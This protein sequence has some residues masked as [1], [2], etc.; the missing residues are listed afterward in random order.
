MRR[1]LHES[2]SKNY[3][4]LILELIGKPFFYSIW[5]VVMLIYILSKALYSWLNSL[6]FPR[7]PRKKLAVFALLSFSTLLFFAIAAWIFSLKILYELPA[8]EELAQRQ[9]DVSS[10]IYD[11]NG[12]LLYS[13]YKD[14]NRSLIKTDE[15]PQQVKLATLAAEDSEFYNHQGYSIKGMAR[16]LWIFIRTG[17]VTGGSTITQQLVKNALLSNEKTLVRK[18]KEFILSLGVE[19]KYTKDQIL[20]MYLNE[21][22]YG[23]V[24]YGIKEAARYY[25]DKDLNQLTIAEAALLAGLTKSPSELSPFGNE[26]GLAKN[27]ALEVIDLM[28]KDGFITEEQAKRAEQEKLPYTQN[29]VDIKA[30]HFVM[31]VRDQLEKSGW[32]NL[33]TQGLSIYTSLDMNVQALVEQVIQNEISNLQR[34]HV[35]N[36]AGMVINSKTGEILAMVGSTNYFDKAND[37]NVNVALRPR[38]PGSS[39]KPINYAYALEHGYTPATI[40]DDSLASFKVEGQP[41]YTPKDYDGKFRGPITLRSAL[42]ESRNI[43]AVKVLNS[44]GVNKMIDLGEEM[45]ITTWGDRKRFG[46]SLTLG[47]GDV[48]LYDLAQAYQIL[49]NYGRRDDL[50]SIEKI[51][52]KDGKVIFE[53]KCPTM[54]C[55]RS[56]IDPRVAFQLTNILSDNKAR[57]PAFGTNSTLVIKNHP[58]VAVKTGTSN[59]LRDNL[60]LGYNQ[61]YL[62]A[63]WVGNN[64]NSPMSRVASGV[65][66]ASSIWNKVMTSLLEDK[67]SLAWSV[68]DGL[69]KSSICSSKGKI[70]DW[71][72]EGSVPS[73]SCYAQKEDNQLKNKKQAESNSKRKP[74]FN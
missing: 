15:I 13:L 27:R 9:I 4:A 2:F 20:T 44:Y 16:A 37:G 10:K 49:S 63:T 43:P 73:Q 55:S 3:A 59:D 34:L 39:I 36:A 65:T 54:N 71:F 12:I 24:V 35:T 26:P 38:Q 53:N 29:K 74:K 8:P 68:P 19:H 6:T 17:K 22:S 42:A 40:I 64:D 14:K 31:F 48:K 33:E 46:L 72:L 1:S 28:Q 60:T 52:N 5:G 45:G 70:E 66:G 11:R 67:K 57:T 7:L 69:V 41:A 51:V 61:D 62:V 50:I 25:F 32:E 58:E 56:V 47:G 30:P 23:G 21:V 18:V